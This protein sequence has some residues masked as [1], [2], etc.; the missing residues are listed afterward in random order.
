MNT[1]FNTDYCPFLVIIA[2]TIVSKN[3]VLL[4][5]IVSVW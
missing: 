3:L 1:L 4:V 5:F 2:P